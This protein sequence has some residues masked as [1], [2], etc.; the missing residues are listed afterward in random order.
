MSE[1][2]DYKELA[3]VL[4]APWFVAGLLV[5]TFPIT[6]YCAW[7]DLHMWNWFV[8]PFLHLP[9]MPLWVAVGIGFW[10]RS[11]TFDH[12]EYEDHKLRWWN[13]VF[14]SI[15]GHTVALGISAF[16]HWGFM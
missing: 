5:V 6:M 13:T 1:K 14:G 9:L 7:C 11:Q 10:I 2:N 8:S 12:R 3:T 4:L 15:I 16:V